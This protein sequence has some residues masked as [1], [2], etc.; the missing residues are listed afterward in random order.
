MVSAP[1][2]TCAGQ[3]AYDAA[4][5]K[6]VA[7]VTAMLEK[8]AKVAAY[9]RVRMATTDPHPDHGF[10]ER[11]V[12]LIRRE[13]DTRERH[14]QLYVFRDYA[15]RRQ[16]IRIWVNGSTAE[17]VPNDPCGTFNVVRS[18]CRDVV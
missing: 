6:G 17:P 8:A 12:T 7:S 15:D 4:L 16:P 14:C 1:C 10:R 5:S 11:W 18:P 2:A 13:L 3:T 9:V